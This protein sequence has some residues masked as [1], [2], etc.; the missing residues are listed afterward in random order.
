MPPEFDFGPDSFHRHLSRPG[1]QPAVSMEIESLALDIDMP[2]DV[3]R[4]CAARGSRRAAE[5]MAMIASA[6]ACRRNF[7]CVDG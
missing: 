5:T 6:A 2:E 4:L 1:R 7:V 3:K